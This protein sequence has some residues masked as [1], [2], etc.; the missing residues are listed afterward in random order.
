MGNQLLQISPDPRHHEIF[1]EVALQV[2]VPPLTLPQLH[3]GHNHDHVH[4]E[5]HRRRRDCVHLHHHDHAISTVI[6]SNK[7]IIRSKDLQA[8]L[9]LLALFKIVGQPHHS[10]VLSKHQILH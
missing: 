3:L 7:K 10:L 4:H 2:G 9:S 6:A 8:S 1:F 5:Q